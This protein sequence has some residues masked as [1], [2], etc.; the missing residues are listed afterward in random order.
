VVKERIVVG[1]GGKVRIKPPMA[2]IYMLPSPRAG[3]RQTVLKLESER[4]EEKRV[5]AAAR[6]VDERENAFK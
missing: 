2:R 5:S 6:G 1:K 4:H 3:G